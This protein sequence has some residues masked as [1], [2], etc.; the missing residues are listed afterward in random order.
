MQNLM[1]LLCFRRIAP[2]NGEFQSILLY[3]VC[4]CYSV[5]ILHDATCGV[6]II[7]FA[8]NEDLIHFSNSTKIGRCFLETSGSMQIDSTVP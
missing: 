2:Q 5:T 8:Y 7:T 4:H 3:I 1:V 6:K